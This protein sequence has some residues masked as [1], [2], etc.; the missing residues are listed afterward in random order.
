MTNANGN[1]GGGHEEH[2]V[3]KL[4]GSTD[5]QLAGY[6]QELVNLNYINPSADPKLRANKPEDR[7]NE[8]SNVVTSLEGVIKD[9]VGGEKALIGNKDRVDMVVEKLIEYATKLPDAK[10]DPKK[11]EQ[12]ITK[13]LTGAGVDYGSLIR[14]AVEVKGGVKI[15]ELP[16]DHPLRILV[17]YIAGGKVPAEERNRFLPRQLVAIGT[18]KPSVFANAMNEYAGTNLDPRVATPQE[19]LSAFQAKLQA[20]AADYR[21]NDPNVVYNKKAA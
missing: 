9:A 20:K 16:E 3:D 10:E 13:Y 4:N 6:V 15:S 11:R 21:A 17:N 5:K 7:G 8:V 1:D 2:L 19:T 12:E 18:S 14:R